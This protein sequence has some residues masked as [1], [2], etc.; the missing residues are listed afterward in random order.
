MSGASRSGGDLR[1][2][3]PSPAEDIAQRTRLG[4]DVARVLPLPW[5][6]APF[7]L[8]DRRDRDLAS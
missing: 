4:A 2:D 3:E 8:D 7:G 6:L 5:V 1:S